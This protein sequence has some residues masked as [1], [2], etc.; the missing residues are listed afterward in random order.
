MDIA[1][2][3]QLGYLQELNRRFLHPLGLAIEIVQHEDGSESL[4][5]VWDYRDDP[6]GLFYDI[7]NAGDKEKEEFKSRA[8]FIDVELNIRFGARKGALGFDIEPSL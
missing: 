5:G 7:A 3:R 6:E 2:F 4:G 8:N 1:E